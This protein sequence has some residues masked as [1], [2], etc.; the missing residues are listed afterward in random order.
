MECAPFSLTSCIKW[1]MI[2]LGICILW[3]KLS[4][5]NS[6][7]SLART[8]SRIFHVLGMLSGLHELVRMITTS[9]SADTLLNHILVEVGH[10]VVW[11]GLVFFSDTSLIGNVWSYMVSIGWIFVVVYSVMVVL[12]VSFYG[13]TFGY[14]IQLFSFLKVHGF[15]V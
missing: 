13:N 5:T 10:T 1:Y 4:A 2:Q 3:G 8:S 12:L 9:Y 6:I 11:E 7:W 15:S 14:Q